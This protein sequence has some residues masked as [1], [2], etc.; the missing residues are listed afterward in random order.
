MC[1]YVC[2]AYVYSYRSALQVHIS[3]VRAHGHLKFTDR[4]LGVGDY[5]E[6]PR[7]AYN[8]IRKP[9]NQ[10]NGGWALGLQWEF[11]ELQMALGDGSVITPQ[12]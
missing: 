6:K 2:T 8:I 9:Q 3:T 11:R 12:L 1:M 10:Q 7:N 4:K 5:M